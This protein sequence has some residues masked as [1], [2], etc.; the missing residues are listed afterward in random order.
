MQ[1]AAVGHFEYAVWFDV[2]G[3]NLSCYFT[4]IK[5]V[6]I[7]CNWTDQLLFTNKM[8]LRTSNSH[9]FGCGWSIL[10][11][12]MYLIDIYLQFLQSH[13]NIMQVLHHCRSRTSFVFQ[14]FLF[15]HFLML[16]VIFCYVLSS[17]L[18]T[19]PSHTV[20]L[21]S[22]RWLRSFS[23]RFWSHFVGLFCLC[24]WL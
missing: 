23:F 1:K 14:I 18:D 19:L 24:T 2:T 10:I 13:L 8:A 6:S 3:I 7:S 9:R 20:I 4:I 11:K 17:V 5:T 12:L 15:F 22:S 16:V 21:S